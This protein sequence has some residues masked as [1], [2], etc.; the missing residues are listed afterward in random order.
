[1][2]SGGVISFPI[3]NVKLLVPEYSFPDKS[4]PETVTL[5]SVET[6]DDTVQLYVQIEAE[7]VALIVVLIST[8]FK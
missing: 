1:M 5:T 4:V 6:V 7:L 2:S 8:P 3:K